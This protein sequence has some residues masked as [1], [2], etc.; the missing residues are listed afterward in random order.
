MLIPNQAAGALLERDYCLRQL[1][2]H[3]TILTTPLHLGDARSKHRVVGWCKRQLVDDNYRQ[4]LTAYINAFPKTL[5]ADK[6]RVAGTT[7]TLE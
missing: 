3:E 6:H 7:K 5:A 4:S 2:M 1:V